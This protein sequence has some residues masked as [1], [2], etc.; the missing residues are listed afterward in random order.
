M[1]N[2]IKKG[3]TLIELLVVI[4]IIGILASMLLPTLAKAK[5]KANRMKC[6]S[7][8]GQQSKAYISQA[9]ETGGFMW[10][11]QDRDALDAYA[12]DYRDNTPT[13][14]HRY[15]WGN[16]GDQTVKG[17]NGVPAGYRFYPRLHMN[18]IRFVNVSPGIRSSLANA[19]MLLSPSDPKSKRFNQLE[20][21]RGKLDGGSFAYIDKGSQHGY[22]TDHRGGSYGFHMGGDDQKAESVLHFTR[23]VQGEGWD[24]AMMPRGW[25]LG[26]WWWVSPTLRVGTQSANENN[27]KWVGVDNTNS[28]GMGGNARGGAHGMSGLDGGQGSY[29][30]ADGSVKQADD[31]QWTAALYTAQKQKGGQ[32]DFPRRGSV[33][34]HL[35]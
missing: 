35:H 6:S 12:S 28:A 23:N 13:T 21:T 25:S 18:D 15:D 3:F 9:G 24:W 11:L 14:D 19:K 22:H 31:G 29:S 20:S 34:R 10:L 4:A 27:H 32:T 5:K 30:T 16:H 8:L 33:S 1:K 7:N 2:Q 17:P 26:G